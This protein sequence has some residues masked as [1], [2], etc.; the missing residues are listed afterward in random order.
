MA[1]VVVAAVAV[2]PARPRADLIG[3][4]GTVRDVAVSPDGARVLT[5]GFDYAARLWDFTSQRELSVLSGHTAPVDAV[6][7]LAR[8]R[9]VTAGGDGRVVIW[10]L[11]DGTPIHTLTGHRM[12]VAAIAVSPSG[13]TLATAGWDRTVRVWSVADGRQVARLD[14]PADVDAVAYARDDRTVVTGGKDGVIRLWALEREDSEREDSERGNVERAQQVGELR[15]HGMGVTD[16]AASADGSRLLTAGIDGT[17]RLWDVARRQELAVLQGHDGPVF[18]VAFSSDGARGVSSGRDGAVLV[19][20]LEKRLP[21]RLIAAHESPAWSVAVTP[22]GRFVLSAGADGSVR[23]WH[24]ETGSRTGAPMAR[25]AQPQP[26]LTS[27]HPGAR[28]YRACAG[29]H[30]LTPGG[31]QRSG[32][33]FAGLFGRRAGSVAGYDYS[34]PLRRAGFVWNAKT[35]R[36]LFEQGPDVFVPGSKMPLQRI[37]D[38]A[39]LNA[40]VDYMR[41]LT[42]DTNGP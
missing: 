42:T 18:G 9:G 32:P 15:G 23:V 4:G 33:H 7:F 19:W 22:D 28:L 29:C 10:D 30:A 5:G 40:L 12:K 39:D 25:D 3:H 34:P 1:A 26:W 14:H 35:L 17:V 24:T 41:I 37:P 11:K 2:T 16:L 6:A 36:A 8:N 13:Q 21:V 38:R 20:D 27:S 31:I